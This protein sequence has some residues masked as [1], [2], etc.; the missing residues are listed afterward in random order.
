MLLLPSFLYPFVELSIHGLRKRYYKQK[1]SWDSKLQM[2]ESD[3]Y[4][5]R[6]MRKKDKMEVMRAI[7][8]RVKSCLD[9]FDML[10]WLMT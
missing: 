8:R 9:L 1:Q 4:L 2:E 7:N 3:Y 5:A 6:L 10:S